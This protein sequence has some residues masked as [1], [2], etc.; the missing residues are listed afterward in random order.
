MAAAFRRSKRVLCIHLQEAVAAAPKTKR[1]KSGCIADALYRNKLLPN[2]IDQD[3]GWCFPSFLLLRN[4]WF[5]ADLR[6]QELK[7]RRSSRDET[8]PSPEGR[9][10]FRWNVTRQTIESGSPLPPS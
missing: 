4:V 10:G 7:P 2:A 8:A 9:S 3:R 5:D 1:S 6:L